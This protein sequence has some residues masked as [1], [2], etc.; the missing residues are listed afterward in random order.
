M[1]E[2]RYQMIGLIGFIIAGLLF[3]WIGLRAEDA[4]TVVASVIW[5]LSCVIWMIPLLRR[6]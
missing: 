5:T 6:K 1:S 3:I 4:L 2:D